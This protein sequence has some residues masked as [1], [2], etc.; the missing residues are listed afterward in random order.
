MKG[1][2][3]KTDANDG[4][5]T[6]H[7]GNNGWGRRNWNV[8]SQTKDSITFGILDESY[9]SNGMPGRVT[10][11]V[12]Y[13]VGEDGWWTI[14]MSA[15]SLDTLTPLMLTQHTYFNLDA[16]ANPETDLILNHTYHTPY[17]R[18][19][20]DIRGDGAPT[21]KINPIAPGSINDFYS[22]PKQLGAFSGNPE[23]VGNCGNGCGGYNNLWI[24]DKLGLP[25]SWMGDKPTFSLASDWSGIKVD[26]YTDQ[27]GVVLYTCFWSDGSQK[28]KKTQGGERFVKSSG[29]VAI[30]AQDWSNGIN[31]PEWKRKQF[32]GPGEKF[33]WHGRYRFSTQK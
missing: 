25:W 23:W 11:R 22:K 24:V 6:L 27:A 32:Y 12:K 30:E 21:G 15:E 33:T 17:S 28:V 20:L 8:I 4:N 10:G 19:M 31:H 2:V 18:R 7:S 13:G 16:Y 1:K 9:S 26:A 3:Y 29:C 14:D 5:N